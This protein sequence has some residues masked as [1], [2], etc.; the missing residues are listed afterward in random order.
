MYGITT[1]RADLPELQ[2]DSSNSAGFSG[3]RQHQPSRCI[4]GHTRKHLSRDLRWVVIERAGRGFPF[5]GM[6]SLMLAYETKTQRF[7]RNWIDAAGGGMELVHHFLEGHAL[8]TPQ[9]TALICG[10][11][12]RSYADID[13]AAIR[14]GQPLL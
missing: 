13:R 11:E 12:R 2:P 6:L 14:L 1:R 10:T 8:H 5:R 7:S 4:D 3:K 9:K